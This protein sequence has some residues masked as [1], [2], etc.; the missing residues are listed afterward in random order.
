MAKDTA[1]KAPPADQ[2]KVANVGVLR[3]KTSAEMR[4]ESETGAAAPSPRDAREA[5]TQAVKASK[6]T[7]AAEFFTDDLS[8][9]DMSGEE[10]EKLV[11]TRLLFDWHDG[12][13]ITHPMGK[14]LSLPWNEAKTLISQGFAERADPPKIET[15]DD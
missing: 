5:H 8:A 1:T 7:S 15:L 9:P 14:I 2:E 10:K 6:N 12:Q 4:A 11:S 13:G 3:V